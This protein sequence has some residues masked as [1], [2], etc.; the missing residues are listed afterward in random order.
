MIS[1]TFTLLSKASDL[2]N[3]YGQSYTDDQLI[4]TI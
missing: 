1:W 2:P 4:F 3:P